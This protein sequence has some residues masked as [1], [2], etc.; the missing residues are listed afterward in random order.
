LIP[1]R[2]QTS[3]SFEVRGPPEVR[4]VDS[5]LREALEKLRAAAPKRLKELR[6]ECASDLERLDNSAAAGPVNA[7]DFFKPLKLALEGGGSSKVVSIALDAIQKLTTYGFLTGRGPD[8]FRDP[9]AP[10]SSRCL[11]DTV[12]EAVCNCT[13][14]ADDTVQL[15]MVR[16]LLTAVTASQPG[17]CEVHGDSLMLAVSTCFKIHRDSKSSMNQRQAQASLT[18]MLNVVTQR[19]EKSAL[20]MSRRTLSFE[21]SSMSRGRTASAMPVPPSDLALLP[22]EQLLNDWMSSYMTRIVDQVV[23]EDARKRPKVLIIWISN[24]LLKR[25]LKFYNKSK[26]HSKVSLSQTAATCFAS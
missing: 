22:K 14:Q 24:Q 26:Y 4:S 10:A 1:G 7:D 2:I 18:Q 17:S 9:A 16:A 8:P 25:I 19:M 11:M 3:Q 15:Q 6:D 13:E 5:V 23:L 12:M 20:D 21:E